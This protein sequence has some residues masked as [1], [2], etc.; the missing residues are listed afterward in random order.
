MI[1]GYSFRGDDDTRTAWE[2]HD[3]YDN[4]LRVLVNGCVGHIRVSAAM[5]QVEW[6]ARWANGDRFDH[7]TLQRAHDLLAAAWR[8]ETVPAQLE[9]PLTRPPLAECQRMERWLRWLSAEIDK[10][11]YHPHAVHWVMT[12][13]THQNQ[14]AGYQA[15]DDLAEW[16]RIRFGTV[17]WNNVAGKRPP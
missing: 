17:P 2:Q 6:P 13:L 12:I 7:R 5:L 9:L 3:V 14:H 1:V 4:A 8:F 15:E 10:W 11:R 16:L